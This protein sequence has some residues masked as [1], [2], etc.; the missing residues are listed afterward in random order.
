MVDEPEAA[1]DELGSTAEATA[2]VL[3]GSFRTEAGTSG[4][5]ARQGDDLLDLGFP[6]PAGRLEHTGVVVRGEVRTEQPHGGEVHGTLGEQVE[7][8]RESPGG[9]GDLHPVV[10][11]VVGEGEDVAQ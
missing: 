9:P 10:G 2:T 5:G 4:R 1:A 11:L 6:L 7:N 3:A 8:D